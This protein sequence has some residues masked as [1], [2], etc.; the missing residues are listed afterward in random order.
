MTALLAQTHFTP[1]DVLRLEDEGLYELVD[2]KLVEKQMSSLA[3]KTAGIVTVKIGIFLEATNVG[4]LFPEQSFQCF[5]DEPSKLRR[6]DIA[7]VC[8]RRL[9]E[10][11]DE[12]HVPIA[13]DL[14]IEVVSPND[15]I[16]ELDAKLVDY[17]SAGVKLVWVVNP[18]SRLVR[19][20]RSDHSSADLQ[21]N[22]T[23]SGESVL[24]GFSILIKDLLPPRKLA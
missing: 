14:A 23:L 15:T 11:P 22:D 2:G 21:E 3:S 6:P 12:G 19:I 24:P 5:P 17:R 8:T 1:D 10:V 18:N 13:P 9:A 16:Y 20:Y 7:F 4:S